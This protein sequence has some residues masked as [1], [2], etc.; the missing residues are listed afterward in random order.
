VNPSTRGQALNPQ[1]YHRYCVPQTR[2]SR[3]YYGLGV[4]VEFILQ[5]P[6]FARKR[7][8]PYD[9]TY[10]TGMSGGF[11]LLTMAA[12][13]IPTGTPHLHP[14]AQGCRTASDSSARTHGSVVRVQGTGFRVQGA[15]CR[16]QGS[17]C[18]VQ[19]VGCRVQGVRQDR[20]RLS[21]ALPRVATLSRGVQRMRAPL[22]FR[23]LGFGFG[24]WGL[25]FGCGVW[26][27]RFRFEGLGFGVWSF[28]V[29]G[30]VWG[31]G[32][33]VE[34]SGFRIFCLGYRVQGLGFRVQGS[35]LR[36][37]GSVFSAQCS[38]FSVQ[39]SGSTEGP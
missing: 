39:C 17:G 12:L 14:E 35:G 37:E 1:P 28:G 29:S 34:G 18:R 38:V 15:G 27:S 20:E 21:R 19:F 5:S 7:N 3:P 8:T 11:R 32:L 25:E 23:V 22:Q 2:H 4:Q 24:V 26:G 6:L 10:S 13:R 16:V 33:R 30:C 36:V 9:D 31:V